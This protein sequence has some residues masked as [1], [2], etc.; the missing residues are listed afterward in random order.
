MKVVPRIL[1]PD[2]MKQVT[3]TGGVERHVIA[4]VVY[5]RNKNPPESLSCPVKTDPKELLMIHFTKYCQ[6]DQI[7]EGDTSVACSTVGRDEICI[8]NFCRKS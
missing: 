4:F 8:Q 6:G 2:A 1:M 5:L 3:Y 7:K